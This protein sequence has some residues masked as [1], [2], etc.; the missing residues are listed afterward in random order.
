MKAWP[1]VVTCLL[2]AAAGVA[3]A[4]LEAPPAAAPQLDW[5]A[6]PGAFELSLQRRYRNPLYAPSRR[7]VTPSQHR[8]AVIR[9]AGEAREALADFMDL[10]LKQR[11]LARLDDP[12]EIDAAVARFEDE[13]RRNRGI[14]GEASKLAD[15][16]QR[17]RALLLSSWRERNAD[18][19]AVQ[20]ELD[21]IQESLTRKA[22]VE[23]SDFVAQMLRKDT[24]IESSDLASALLSED[25]ATIKLAMSQLGNQRRRKVR[26]DALA[27]VSYVR[28]GGARIEG[29]DA[30]LEA[31][32]RAR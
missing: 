12:A 1:A 15:E 24:P 6:N 21:E 23:N 30:R 31:L 32:Q 26:R 19:E 25:V 13:I 11:R 14:G 9:D 16:L 20:V 10:A 18:S 7:R 4:Q 22:R 8:A 5:S 29:F 17:I 3:G 28:L 27:V 2:I